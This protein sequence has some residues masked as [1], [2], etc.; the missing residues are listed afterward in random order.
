MKHVCFP[1]SSWELPEHQAQVRI[2]VN[3]GPQFSENMDQGR[4]R[5]EPHRLITDHC[6]PKPRQLQDWLM[7][8]LAAHFCDPSTWQ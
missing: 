8:S 6:G 4:H 1:Q 3:K 7:L 2:Y 5:K